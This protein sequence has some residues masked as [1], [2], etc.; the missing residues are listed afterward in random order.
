MVGSIRWRI[1]IPYIVLTLLTFS[2]LGIYLS[3]FVRRSHL[4]NLEQQLTQQTLL[5]S[6]ALGPVMA[7]DQPPGHF[8]NL[9]KRWSRMINSRVTIIDPGGSVLGDSHEEASLMDNHLDRVEVQQALATGLGSSIR[10]SSTTGYNMMYIA[11]PVTFEGKLVGITRLALPVQQVEE[12]VGQVQRTLLTTTLFAMLLVVLLAVAIAAHTTSPLRRLSKAARD[13]SSS[14]EDLLL[15]SSSS[16]EVG[17]LAKAF[18]RR[19]Q[20]LQLQMEALKSESLKLSSV[21]QQMTD[22]VLIID[23]AGQV[24]LVNAAAELMFSVKKED[25]TGR[26]LA[27]LLRHYQVVELW[28]NALKSGEAQTAAIEFGSQRLALQGLATPLGRELPGYT[29]MVFQDL[30]RLHQLETIR[31]DFISNI[32]HE[33]RTPLA[34]L[35]ALA[36]TLQESALEDPPAARRFLQRMDTELDALTQMIS[37]LLE[38]ARIES[39]KALLHFKSTY[40]ADIVEPAVDRLRLQVERAGLSLEVDCP[41]DLPPVLV[42][43]PRIEQVIV[44]LLHNAIKFTGEGGSIRVAVYEKDEAVIFSITDTGQGISE[45]DLSRIFER[46]YKS[47]RS[48]ARA[49]TGLGLA[50]ARHLVEAH[51]GSIWAESVEGQ[52]STFYFSL[53]TFS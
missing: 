2:F 34:S 6:D 45:I 41:G 33:L 43:P 7:V 52:G 10:Y 20:Q 27:E 4:D 48:R 15:V 5:V 26:S 53:P 44:N 32:S 19:T 12:T 36:E 49:G 40:P 35:K 47:D 3:N 1:A 13:L 16:D 37:E 29:L 21:L 51:G 31:R 18:N 42:D 11:V 9:A 30:T 46:F 38:L 17:Q 39:G 25:S 50:I 28:R 23:S 8:T 22:G 24:Q 14:E